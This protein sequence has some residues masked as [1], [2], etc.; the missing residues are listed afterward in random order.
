MRFLFINQYY[1]PDFAATAQQMTDLCEALASM[2]H[3]VHVLASRALYDGRDFEL[4]REETINGVK[5]HRIGLATNRRDHLSQRLLGYASFYVKALARVNFLPRPDMV[6]ALTTPPLISLLGTW[7]RVARKSR[8]VYWVMDVY[9][10]IA[11]K[12]GLFSRFGPTRSAW[13]FLGRLSMKTANRVVVLGHDMKARVMSK[14]VPGSKVDVIQSWACGEEISPEDRGETNPFARAHIPVGS[15]SVMYSGNM[16]S[17]HTFSEI[18]GAAKAFCDDPGVQF[19]FVGGGNQ[20]PYLKERL[21]GQKQN[22]TFLPYQEREDLTHS[23]SAPDV[24]LITLQSRYDGLLV[25]SKLYAIMAAGRPVLLVGSEKNEVARII[26]EARCGV[27]CPEG[28]AESV[29]R[30][31]A[32]MRDDPAKREAMGRRGRDYFIRHFDRSIAMET[33]AQM[34]EREGLLPGV[35]G[36]RTLGHETLRYFNRPRPGARAVVRWTPTRTA[37]WPPPRIEQHHPP[38]EPL[39]VIVG[40]RE[41]QTGS[42]SHRGAGITAP[43]GRW[44]LGVLALVPLLLAWSWWHYAT[45]SQRLDARASLAQAQGRGAASTV[46]WHLGHP[47]SALPDDV[48]VLEATARWAAD[49]ATP[50]QSGMAREA[51][52]RALALAPLRSRL[53]IMLGR[54][55]LFDGRGDQARAALAFSDTLDPAF[56]SER[57]R[58]A[59]YW[60]LLGE[61]DRALALARDAASLDDA[62]VVEAARALRLMG[63]SPRAAFDAVYR[64]GIHPGRFKDL[65]EALAST[66]PDAMQALWAGLPDS[67]LDVP[68]A[69]RVVVQ[70][71]LDP[72]AAGAVL[73]AWSR[74]TGLAPDGQEPY[75]PNAGLRT[76]PFDSSLPVGWILPRGGAWDGR[77][78]WESGTEGEG[79]ALRV[80]PPLARGDSNLRH[81]VLYRFLLPPDGRDYRVGLR[82]A[83]DRP[84]ALDALLVV[85]ADGV[86]YPGDAAA[87]GRGGTGEAWVLVPGAG[88][89]R[90][91][92]LSLR[93]QAH[94]PMRADP[95]LY[96][97]DMVV[98]A[99]AEVAG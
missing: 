47:V 53:W 70:A 72:L 78:R 74:A 19:L 39:E 68:D 62:G 55:Q 94:E 14:G 92:T 49:R 33:F 63:L 69:P 6:V 34:L 36:V 3:D 2:G 20:L 83:V 56:P 7:L 45:V 15:F 11:V 38:A 27:I 42:E 12:A 52:A 5:V 22:V 67:A 37:S 87:W 35:R 82:L 10:D 80:E 41:R 24:H 64:D 50:P 86:Q 48:L 98:D 91:A 21:G 60:A 97:R 9:P 61:E 85:S 65:V 88:E 1:A 79:G 18:A 4:P 8:F 73:R 71:A 76:N 75:L 81:I 84:V 13:S 43:P 77:I 54:V 28:D 57:L 16:G 31:L 93:I 44:R 99:V 90:V 51:L 26:R 25:P 40:E 59:R 23:L 30:A 89:W 96:L 32:A 58:A 66:D 95:V 46:E 29:R 17:C